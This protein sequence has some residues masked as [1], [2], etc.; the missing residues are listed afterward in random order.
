MGR[1][2]W[3]QEEWYA[4]LPGHMMRGVLMLRQ[5][6]VPNQRRLL[7]S[8]RQLIC[9]LHGRPWGGALYLKR[10]QWDA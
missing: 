3:T 10:G 9:T 4:V 6:F 1:M 8:V 2:L 5:Q 7:C